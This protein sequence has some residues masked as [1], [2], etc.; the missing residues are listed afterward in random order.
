MS[1]RCCGSGAKNGLK[2]AFF[3]PFFGKFS[4]RDMP[5]REILNEYSIRFP[6]V[7]VRNIRTRNRKYPDTLPAKLIV[8]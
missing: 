8:K 4:L 7:C 6:G 1:T 2:S 3:G 5:K